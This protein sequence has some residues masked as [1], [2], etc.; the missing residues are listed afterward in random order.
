M[1]DKDKGA[2]PGLSY[3]EKDRGERLAK[4]ERRVE[5]EQRPNNSD[6][7]L[8]KEIRS[9]PDEGGNN[10]ELKERLADVIAAMKGH[11]VAKLSPEDAAESK[12]LGRRWD[13]ELERRIKHA[14]EDGLHRWYHMRKEDDKKVSIS[15]VKDAVKTADSYERAAKELVGYEDVKEAIASAVEYWII[16]DDD[17]RTSCKIKPPH[18]FILTGSS[19]TG[20]TH[21]A[22]AAMYEAVIRGREKDTAIATFTPEVNDFKGRY[23]GWAEDNTNKIFDKAMKQPSILFIDEAETILKKDADDELLDGVRAGDNNVHKIIVEKINKINNEETPCVVVLA[24]YDFNM[25]PG[26]VKRRANLGT[27]DLDS[28]MT[29]PMLVEITRR[30]LEEHSVGDLKAEDVFA[31]IEKK[32]KSIGHAKVTPDDISKTFEKVMT[33]KTK[34]LRKSYFRRKLGGIAREQEAQVEITL[35]DFKE[36]TSRLKDYADGS[37][38][39]EIKGMVQVVRPEERLADVGG[40]N[41]VKYELANDIEIALNRELAEKSGA[42]PP[43]GVL[44]YGPP[45]N[46]KTLIAKAIAGELDATVYI[47]QGAEILRKWRGESEQIIKSLFSEARKTSPSIIF[48][49]EVDA[50]ATKRE[51]LNAPR[52]VITSLLSEMGGVK[53]MEGVV[54]VATTNKRDMLDPAFLRS[55]RFDIQI[56]IPPPKNDEERKEI[57]GVHLKKP[58]SLG[59]VDEAVT[60]QAILDLFKKRTFI[61]AKISR[62]VNDAGMLRTRELAAAQNIANIREGDVAKFEKVRERYG[63]EL[64]RLYSNLDFSLKLQ[65]MSSAELLPILQ[66]VMAG[67]NFNEYKLNMSHFRLAME[68]SKDKDIERV[69]KIEAELRGYDRKPTV[70]LGWGIAA[71]ESKTDGG[72]HVEGGVNG[73]QCVVNPNPNGKGEGSATFYGGEYADSIKASA[74]HGRVFLNDQCEWTME[75]YKFYLD[76]VGVTK[77]ADQKIVQG[78]SAGGVITLTEWS[79][80]TKQKLLPNVVI[81]CTMSPQGELGPVGGLDSE[82]MGKIVAALET[83]GVDTMIIH[84]IN[85]DELDKKDIKYIESHGIKLVPVTRFWQIPEIAAE[86]HPGE[87]EAI[88][89]LR[90]LAKSGIKE[91]LRDSRGGQR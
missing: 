14:D 12:K 79:A 38:S 67:R 90:A 36:G 72:A 9:L 65:K 59:L 44:L 35:D 89:M 87:K 7:Q 51:D 75:N 45:G 16:K 63:N 31:I 57:I 46:G 30:K 49:D 91:S 70:G 18:L 22:R 60:E 10:R 23:G 56:E 1:P 84:K 86:S 66:E 88:N 64:E 13:Q 39:P 25:L 21:L 77:G 20:K 37:V 8:I 40:L 19:G 26:D 73:I 74:E 80:A 53:P 52:D 11:D 17:Y 54:V 24:T 15:S 48:F 71:F 47:V 69:K 32:V 85:Y 2:D 50:I 58:R 68:R 61:P 82:G 6:F 3:P 29:R 4:L 42:T 34:H 62:I 55:G 5:R 28:E 76:F 41:D 81:T 78:P 33:E 27:F 43:R 83:Y